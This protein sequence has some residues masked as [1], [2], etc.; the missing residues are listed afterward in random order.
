MADALAPAVTAG[1]AGRAFVLGGGVA[2]IAA[3][4]GLADQGAAVTLLEQHSWLGGRAFAR[5]DARLGCVRDNGPHVVLGCYDEFRRLLRALGTEGGFVAADT[6]RVAYADAAGG[7]A[8]LRLPA[9][10]VA[11]AM[12]LGVLRLRAMTLGERLR[13]LLG[14]LGSVVDRSRHIDLE[15]WL[16]RW[17]QHGGPRK[18]LW[19]PLCLAVMNA[20]PSQ[21]SARLFL[22]TLRRLG[23]GGAARGAIWLPDRPWNEILGE[24]ALARLRAH[25]ADVQLGARVTRLSVVGTRVAAIEVAGREP[26]AVGAGD[27]VVATLPWHR[28][29]GCLPADDPTA[30]A[31]T[32]LRASP[33]V[34]VHFA[35][36]ADPP[37]PDAALVALVDG[38][39]FHFLLRRPSEPKR[40]FAVLAGGAD[41]LE[42]ASAETIVALACAQLRR[43]FPGLGADPTRARVVKEARATFV[44]SPGADASRPAC[45]RHPVLTNLLLAGDWCATGLPSTLESAAASVARAGLGVRAHARPRP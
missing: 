31:A 28:L 3:A 11:L 43:H 12:P 22:A 26:I 34:T 24:P 40:R 41:T 2:G 17:R 5:L 13:T 25:G 9:L 19:Q 39:P 44:G 35:L 14:L 45:G 23:A 42:G 10:P 7:R 37:L 18:Y 33:I 20:T 38:E 29:A 27:L 36:D 4:V 32:R 16:R 21:V 1:E 8:E 15:R 30:A 6:L